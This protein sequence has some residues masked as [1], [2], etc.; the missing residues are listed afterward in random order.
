MLVCMSLL[1]GEGAAD[2]R[3]APLDPFVDSEATADHGADARRN[4][5]V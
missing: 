4:L 3:Q 2:F 5:S 1:V